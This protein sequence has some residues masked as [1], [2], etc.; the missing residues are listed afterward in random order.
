MKAFLWLYFVLCAFAVI[1][2]TLQISLFQYPRTVKRT[3]NDDLFSLLVAIGWGVW[4][5]IILF[6]GAS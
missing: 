3:I 2:R 5:G 6:G 1:A 4:V